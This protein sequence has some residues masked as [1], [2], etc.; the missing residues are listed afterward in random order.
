MVQLKNRDDGQ[1]S[2]HVVGATRSSSTSA[3]DDKMTA[4]A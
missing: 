4:T 3:W 1:Q 2:D